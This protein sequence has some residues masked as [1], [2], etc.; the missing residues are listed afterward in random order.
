MNNLPYLRN[1]SFANP[2]LL[3]LFCLFWSSVNILHCYLTLCIGGQIKLLHRFSANKSFS[4]LYTQFINIDTYVL[5][6]YIYIIKVFVIVIYSGGFKLKIH[7]FYVSLV[8]KAKYQHMGTGQYH[9]V[10]KPGVDIQM[11]TYCS[12]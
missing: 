5:L 2:W 3:R 11:T 12:C 8:M 10:T 4:K 7:I 6:L 1:R 9:V